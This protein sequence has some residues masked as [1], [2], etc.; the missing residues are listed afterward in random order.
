MA[1]TFQADILK[2][3][4]PQSEGSSLKGKNVFHWETVFLIRVDCFRERKQ[5][6]ENYR[7]EVMGWGWGSEW[8]GRRIEGKPILG[9]NLV[10]V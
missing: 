1:Y 4:L 3:V 2:I 9:L 5:N 7:S 6:A 8:R 10:K